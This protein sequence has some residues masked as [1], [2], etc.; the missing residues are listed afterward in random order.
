M[1]SKDTLILA[2]LQIG[3]TTEIVPHWFRIRDLIKHIVTKVPKTDCLVLPEYSFLNLQQA[4]AEEEGNQ[5]E[6][7]YW[8]EYIKTG[9]SHLAKLHNLIIVVGSV[10]HIT[11]EGHFRNRSFVFDCSGAVAGFYD[12]QHPFRTEKKLGLEPGTH[13][14]VFQINGLSFAV[15]IC[16][17]LWYHGLITKAAN[18]ADFLAVPTMTTVLNRDYI[19]YGKWAWQSLVAVRAKEYTIPIVSADHP[20]RECSPGVFTC[21][22]SCIA[23]PSYR[24]TEREGPESQAL[25]IVD[26]GSSYVVSQL[27]LTALREY[28]QYRRDV[29]LRED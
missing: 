6:E 15:L 19:T 12:K 22:A 3:S 14:P 29:G 24:F 23:D 8:F 21:G 16:S 5:L 7:N 27:S 18:Q 13:T 10:P 2:A 20:V 25:K 1:G 9:M 26:I 11:E 4:I 17:D 28:A